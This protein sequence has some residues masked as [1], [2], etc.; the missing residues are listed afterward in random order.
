[1]LADVSSSS[2]VEWSCRKFYFLTRQSKIFSHYLKDFVKKK[3][4]RFL[5]TVSGKK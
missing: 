1:M 5:S 4:S 3:F 2:T